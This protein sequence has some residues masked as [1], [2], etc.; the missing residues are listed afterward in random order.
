MQD[1]Y[2]GIKNTNR[3]AFDQAIYIKTSNI[4]HTLVGNNIVDHTDA[5]GAAAASTTTSSLST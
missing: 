1:N 4:S 2:L 5:V 3:V